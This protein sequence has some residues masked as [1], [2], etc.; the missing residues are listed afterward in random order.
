ME[1]IKQKLTVMLE[2]L[3]TLTESIELFNE[4]ETFFINNSTQ[5]NGQILKGM[6]DSM[7]QRFEYCTDIFWKLIKMYLEDVE[8]IDIPITSPRGIIRETVKVKMLSEDEGRECMDMIECRNKTSH[9]Y[10]AQ[11]AQEIA[12][13]IPEYYTLL[14]KLIERVQKKIST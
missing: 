6:R 12:Q 7:I 8:K 11:T 4:Y 2:A 1:K 10:H 3:A 5:K 9:M 14:T 13:Q